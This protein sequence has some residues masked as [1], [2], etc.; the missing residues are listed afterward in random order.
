M[1]KTH[2]DVDILHTALQYLNAGLCIIP[3]R[4]ADK[5]PAISGW[6]PFQERRPS[7]DTVREWFTDDGHTG[8]A[9]LGGRVSGGLFIIDF[10][11]NAEDVFP[12]WMEF[13]GR[14]S[15]MDVSTWPVVRTGKGYHVYLRTATPPRNLE[16]AKDDAGHIFIETRGEGG[17]VVAPPTVHSSPLAWPLGRPYC[18]VQG[19]IL[20]IPVLDDT[21]TAFVLAACEFFDER[22]KPAEN[23]AR[24]AASAETLATLVVAGTSN[25][26]GTEKNAASGLN[27]YAEKAIANQ[28]ER[29]RNAVEGTRNKTIYIAAVEFGKLA[30]AGLMNQHEIETL[31]RPAAAGYIHTDGEKSFTTTVASGVADG[32]A[33]QWSPPPLKHTAN[34]ERNGAA[35]R[36]GVAE[37]MA[38]HTGDSR[39]RDN[40]TPSASAERNA[41]AIDAE[42]ASLMHTDTG[43]A[44]RLV[45]RHGHNLRYV[46]EW[47]QWLVWDGM[48][49]RRDTTSRVQRM[50]KDTVRAM[51]R[52]AATIEDEER[53]KA[54]ASHAAKSENRQRLISMVE[55]AKSEPK[56]VVEA[57]EMDADG[58]LLAVRNGVVDLR[59]G[60]LM[61]H[62]RSFNLMRMVDV[63]YSAAAECP[64]WLAFLNTIFDGDTAMIDF[65]QRAC[66][67]S[68]TGDVSEQV[69][70]FMHGTG[71]NGKSTFANTLAAA[72]GDYY[73]KLSTESLMARHYSVVPADIAA[74]PGARLAVAAEVEAG[75]RLAETLVKDLVG[76]DDIRARFLHQNWFTFRPSAKL[77]IYGNSRPAI[78]GTDDGIWRRVRLIPFG[79]QIPAERVDGRLGEKL[80][81]E[82][83]GI[84]AWMVAGCLAWQQ[85]GLGEPPAVKDATAAYRE[86]MD[87]LAEFLA[88]ACDINAGST[89]NATDVFH[90]FSQWCKVNGE[91]AQ[92]Q[93]AFGRMLRERGYEKSRI[94]G[95]RRVYHGLRL[96]EN[97]REMRD[98][99]SG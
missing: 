51:Y 67:Y 68:L 81:H 12:A 90:A 46:S 42:L 27:R 97:G 7:E 2:D 69:F 48:V 5:K 3:V 61:E 57:S 58:W 60:R 39:P 55:L 41:A 52:E 73:Q 9:I 62:A 49:W 88:E 33:K 28:L 66:G 65:I 92:T 11:M 26:N 37:K 79:V 85:N 93:T 14:N 18:M 6:K 76:G 15:T 31:L 25:G 64:T 8:L 80:R 70:F 77:W 13:V 17:Y 24:P 44:E 35:A 56:V 54:L 20:A 21:E 45:E 89:E 59:T 38:G 30:S 74:L 71:R 50:A 96:N 82:L 53:R 72:T 10:D 84:L 91:K 83:A 78:R 32:L 36:N 94:T 34:G 1:T 99:W 43:N 75:H 16:L 63:E 98:E 86:E 95:G 22:T 4:P 47:N 23:A 87:F 29:V 19:S 40:Q